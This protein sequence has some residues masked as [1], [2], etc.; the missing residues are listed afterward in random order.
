MEPVSVSYLLGWPMSGSQS[1]M[2]PDMPPMAKPDE[3]MS[4]PRVVQ[5]GSVKVIGLPVAC[6]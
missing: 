6:A 2:H 3:P 4:A 1:A 5:R